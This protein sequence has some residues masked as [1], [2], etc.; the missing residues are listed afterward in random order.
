MAGIKETQDV[1]KLVGVVV[2]SILTEVKKDG[3]QVTD[4]A[5]FLKSPEWASSLE[6]AL[7]DA[8]MIVLE[9]ADISWLEGFE[10]GKDVY[11]LVTDVLATLQEPAE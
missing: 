2:K 5:A 9:V 8:P 6:E 1:I 4:L 10:L 7:K 11:D 3:F